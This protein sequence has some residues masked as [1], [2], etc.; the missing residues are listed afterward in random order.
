MATC[1]ATCGQC[2]S[3]IRCRFSYLLLATFSESSSHKHDKLT[4]CCRTFTLALARLSCYI[5]AAT[6]LIPII[7]V[8]YV[9]ANFSESKFLGVFATCCLSCADGRERGFALGSIGVEMNHVTVYK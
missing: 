3:T 9:Y 2:E 6:V 4:Q 1:V 7:N 5:T 8:K